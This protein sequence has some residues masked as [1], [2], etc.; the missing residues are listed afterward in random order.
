MIRNKQEKQSTIRWGI[1]GL[2]KIAHKFAQDLLHVAGAELQAVASRDADKAK[3]FGEQYRANKYYASY[4]ELVTDAEVDVVYIATPHT[5]HWQHS[6]MSLDA[7]K[8]VL[9]E[10]P[11]GMNRL[12]VSQM[13]AKAREKNLFLMEALWTRFIPATVRVLEI[14]KSKQLGAL[15]FMRADFGFLAELA[16]FDRIYN[17]QL[18]GGSL[19]DIGIYPIYLSLLALGKPSTIK[20]T[21]RFTPSEVDAYCG[22]LFEYDTQQRAMLESTIEAQT[23]TEAILYGENGFLKMHRSFHHT[24]KISLSTSKGLTEVFSIPYV[25][26]GY[27][28]EIKEVMNCL[29]N[30]KT[31]SNKVPLNTS[32]ALIDIMDRVRNEIGLFYTNE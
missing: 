30:G 1:I 9:C 17:K 19:L 5:F 10:K 21:A 26:N 12:E 4:A 16:P 8:H 27:F 18:G 3:A 6:M 7:G 28:H 15:T 22:M 25:G 2:G 14:L 23:P 24:Q 32:L 31:E 20:A 11:M 29:L 13:A